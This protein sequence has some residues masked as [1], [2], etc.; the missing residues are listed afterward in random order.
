[1]EVVNISPSLI[2]VT[3]GVIVYEAASKLIL[4]LA[5]TEPPSPSLMLYVKEI[6][7]FTPA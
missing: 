6:N 3:E 7:P 1:M 5:F 4:L 2:D